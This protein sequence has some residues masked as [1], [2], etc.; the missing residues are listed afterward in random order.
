MALLD[1][2]PVGQSVLRGDRAGARLQSYVLS[3]SDH[4]TKSPKFRVSR[5]EDVAGIKGSRRVLAEIVFADSWSL[6]NFCACKDTTSQIQN[7]HTSSGRAK[8][9]RM[10]TAFPPRKRL[11]RRLDSLG[12]QVASSTLSAI[13]RVSGHFEVP[14]SA[15]ETGNFVGRRCRAADRDRLCK[16]TRT[17]PIVNV[18]SRQRRH[19]CSVAIQRGWCPG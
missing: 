11:G 16:C 1:F 6:P 9:S 15:T 12:A 18:I 4:L 5:C 8:R 14:S 17:G 7:C 13:Y 2:I 3:T 10:M 19:R